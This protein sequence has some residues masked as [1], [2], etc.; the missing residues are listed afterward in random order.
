VDPTEGWT[1]PDPADYS[2]LDWVEAFKS[3][4]RKFSREYAFTAWKRVDW[5]ALYDRFL[6]RIVQAQAT[7]DQRG[8]YL[9]LHE[10]VCSIPDG[11]VSLAAK[12]P[13]LVSSICQGRLGGGYGLAVAELDDGR[14][15]VGALVPG[16]SA[17]G[18]G[19]LP[20]AEVLAWGGQPPWA[21]IGAINLAATPYRMLTGAY[22]PSSENPKA[23]GVSYRLEQARLLVRGPVDATVDVRFLNP[24][25]AQARTATLRAVEDGGA[26]F[27]L[28]DF[29]SR[30]D[31]TAPLE[32]RILPEGFGY[33]RIPLLADP[34]DLSLYPSRIFDAIKAAIQQF[35]DAKAPA[36]ILDLRGCYG[37][38]DQLAADLCGFFYPQ[39]AFYEN[40]EMFDKRTGTFIRGEGFRITPQSPRFDGAVVVLASSTTTSS[41]EGPAAFLPR[42]P[43][44]RL[45]GFHGT[46]GSFGV[47]GTDIQ[48]PGGYRIRYPHGRSM[49]ASWMVQLDSRNGVGGAVPPS[50]VPKTLQNVL[51]Y[52]AGQDVELREAVR[53]LQGK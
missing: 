27:P 9:A 1:P 51:D 18:A 6:P 34:G 41:G 8:Y 47:V 11:H 44:G 26:T 46:N 49:D 23:T 3:A 13:A 42:L 10:Y 4:H 24:G 35:N 32:A 53:Y 30:P 45:M 31:F 39:P 16:G 17:E 50:P 12:D 21:A 25:A 36:V 38:S 37:G 5:Q 48:M 7:G 33:L 28:L 40:F 2:A 29:A 52:A 20:G 22:S 43:K 19:I 15:V 14:T